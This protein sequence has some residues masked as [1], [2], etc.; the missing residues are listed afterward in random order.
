MQYRTPVTSI[1][2]LIYVIVLFSL[3]STVCTSAHVDRDHAVKYT[4]RV[5]AAVESGIIEKMKALLIKNPELVNAQDDRRFTPLHTAVFYGKSHIVHYLLNEYNGVPSVNLYAED[6]RNLT[7]FHLAVSLGNENIT[8][9]FINS[10]EHPNL[11]IVAMGRRKNTALHIAARYRRHEIASS[12]LELYP[13]LTEI[14]CWRGHLPIHEA[15]KSGDVRLLRMLVQRGDRNTAMTPSATQSLPLHYSTKFCHVEATRLLIKLAP[16]SAIYDNIHGN[17]PLH[18]AAEHCEDNIMR[19]LMKQHCNTTLGELIRVLLGNRAAERSSQ[20]MN[21]ISD[22][23]SVILNGKEWTGL[24]LKHLLNSWNASLSGS[25]SDVGDIGLAHHENSW[26]CILG[27]RLVRL[28]NEEGDTPLHSAASNGNN[29]ALRVMLWLSSESQEVAEW[30]NR[31]GNAPIHVAAIHGHV[32]VL[33]TLANYSA[34]HELGLITANSSGGNTPLHHAVFYRRGRMTEAILGLISTEEAE[35]KNDDGNAAIHLAAEW[36]FTKNLRQIANKAPNSS[37]MTGAGGLT[38]LHYAAAKGQLDAVKVLINEFKSG[39]D[40]RS[41]NG[42]FPIH[43]AAQ[44]GHASVVFYLLSVDNS[45]ASARDGV[46]NYTILHYAIVNNDILIVGALLSGHLI[47]NIESVLSRSIIKALALNSTSLPV[48]H[49]HGYEAQRLPNNVT[50]CEL[51][52]GIAHADSPLHL[53]VY[54]S[55][56]EIVESLLKRE[57]CP[58]NVNALNHQSESALHVSVE[59]K[60]LGLVKMLVSNGAD[61][62]LKD[63]EGLTPLERAIGD[64]RWDIAK[65]L[66]QRTMH[67]M[68]HAIRLENANASAIGFFLDSKEASL[69]YLWDRSDAVH[70]YSETPLQWA[71]LHGWVDTAKR[72]IS[73]GARV[74]KRFVGSGNTCLHAAVMRNDLDM[75]KLVI[76][77]MHGSGDNSEYGARERCFLFGLRNKNDTTALDTAENLGYLEVWTILSREYMGCFEFEYPEYDIGR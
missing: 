21:V 68:H 48:F 42:S 57:T 61:T 63:G 17:T 69:P 72:L 67:P 41:D 4:R 65:Y 49:I 71:V 14:A 6:E 12:L 76:S 27:E 60:S 29:N 33:Y 26:V 40:R 75:V 58:A 35:L 50:I 9:L 2:L 31:E 36:G 38:P 39:W 56:V 73:A 8:W 54:H 64:H 25:R 62:E 30:K 23:S 18:W 34:K 43:L 16:F 37:N 3:N 53:A 19:V 15:A 44:N 7:S 45:L 77:G 66:V 59:R 10:T 24:D 28:K 46:N 55:R 70:K 47:I 5:H 22:V 52:E 32:N 1:L 20:L 51:I 13:Q 11:A 74:E